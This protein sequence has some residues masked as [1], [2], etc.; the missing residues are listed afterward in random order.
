MKSGS[1]IKKRPQSI[2]VVSAELIKLS[3]P[4]KS[5]NKNRLTQSTASTRFYDQS[6]DKLKSK[7]YHDFYL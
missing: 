5:V 3:G 2:E 1:S 7:R 6:S 4:E